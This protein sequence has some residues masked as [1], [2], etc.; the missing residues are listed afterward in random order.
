TVQHGALVVSARGI[1]S[2]IGSTSIWEGGVL[3][4]VGT[5]SRYPLRGS[6]AA[7]LGRMDGIG[8]SAWTLPVELQLAWRLSPHLA[9]AAYG[10]GSFTGP[11]QMLGATVAVQLG[12]WH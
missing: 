7:G 5:P 1:R 9:I 3:A 12:T 2:E 8:A 6:V 4:G 10:F 11:Q